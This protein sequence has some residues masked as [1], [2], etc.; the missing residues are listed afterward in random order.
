MDAKKKKKKIGTVYHGSNFTAYSS[1][2]HNVRFMNESFERH[3]EKNGAKPDI[4]HRVNDA[5][6]EL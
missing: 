4:T 1:I 2:T 5:R 6:A 3:V